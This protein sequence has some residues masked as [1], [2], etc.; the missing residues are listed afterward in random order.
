MDYE[1]ILLP[2]AGRDIEEFVDFIGLVKN[3]PQ[4]AKR[5]FDELSGRIDS[6]SNQPERFALI[7][8]SS[9]FEF[10]VRQILHHSHRVLYAVD[11]ER[12]RVVVLRIW[13][14]NRKRLRP[15]DLTD[16]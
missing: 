1:V 7:P 2:R 15:S 5:W 4:S 16:Q 8:E 14:G 6:L 9:R 12:R 10:G 11:E 3:E 13:H